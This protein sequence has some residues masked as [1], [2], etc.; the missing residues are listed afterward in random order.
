MVVFDLNSH[1][2]AIRKQLTKSDTNSS[3]RLLLPTKLVEDHV[4]PM[5]D[6]LGI[7]EIKSNRVVWDMNTNSEHQLT[8]KSYV[9]INNWKQEFVLR[10]GEEIGLLWNP[11]KSGFCFCVRARRGN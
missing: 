3:S 2:S 8:F 4:L 6:P 11:V 10:Q 1:P 9:L 5:F 7:A